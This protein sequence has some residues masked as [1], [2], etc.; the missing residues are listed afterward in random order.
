MGLFDDAMRD[1]EEERHADIGR[2]LPRRRPQVARGNDGFMPPH[3]AAALMQVEEPELWAMVAR[4]LLDHR[5]DMFG[6]VLVRP[7]IVSA[8]TI[9]T[10]A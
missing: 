4:G 10:V 2:R 7:A 6:D 8:G 3:E 5:R 1:H 9:R